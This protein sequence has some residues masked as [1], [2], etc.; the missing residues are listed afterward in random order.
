MSHFSSNL[1]ILHATTRNGQ[2][3]I[4]VDATSRAI[5]PSQ[6]ARDSGTQFGLHTNSK[7]LPDDLHAWRVV[8]IF[9]NHQRFPQKILNLYAFIRIHIGHSN[10]RHQIVFV[11]SR[12][13]TYSCLIGLGRAAACIGGT[14]SGLRSASRAG[15]AS[16]SPMRK[17]PPLPI[18][19]HGC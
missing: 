11:G 12:S 9:G 4:V 17:T 2:N 19:A 14:G 7:I 13:R 15:A 3:T 6:I 5:S 1:T 10:E 8:S 18:R 16:V